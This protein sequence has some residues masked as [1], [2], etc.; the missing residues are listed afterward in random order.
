VSHAS[1][2]IF[3]RPPHFQIGE[4]TGGTGHPSSF[5]SKKGKKE[6]N[7]KKKKQPQFFVD[8]RKES[9]YEKV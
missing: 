5:K 3:H 4:A 8:N 1:S 9:W 6:F 2:D 7:V